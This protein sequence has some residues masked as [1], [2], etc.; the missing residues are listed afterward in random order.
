MS[1][2]VEVP[3]V[4]ADAIID[5][6]PRDIA[7]L[8]LIRG[9]KALAVLKVVTHYA[10]ARTCET[11]VSKFMRYLANHWEAGA[12]DARREKLRNLAHQL[13]RHLARQPEIHL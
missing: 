6:R 4:L 2:T 9:D 11:K 10:E 8:A 5:L 3:T 7:L 12:D 1:V 13:D